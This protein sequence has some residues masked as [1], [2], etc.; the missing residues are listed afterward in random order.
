MCQVPPI[1]THPA[2]WFL[3]V[4]LDPPVWQHFVP[5]F[6]HESAGKAGQNPEVLDRLAAPLG[7]DA[8]PSELG[9]ADDMQP[10]EFG[11]DAQ[12]R[13]IGMGDFCLDLSLA[14]CN[15][16][17]TGYVQATVPSTSWRAGGTFP[18]GA[19]S[20]HKLPSVPSTSKFLVSVAKN[21]MTFAS[22]CW[23]VGGTFPNGACSNHNLPSVPSTTTLLMSM[24]WNAKTFAS[25]CWRFGGT[26]PK[27]DRSSHR[28]P[29]VPRTQTN[30]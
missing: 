7:M 9:R 2:D 12:T 22:I 5:R 21:S 6:T 29:S 4:T 8:V 3:Y 15:S 30:A 14:N 24:A 16:P 10:V 20:H 19:C 23:R 26:F 1:R 13:F 28:L 18:N 11:C 27:G 25:I 17:G